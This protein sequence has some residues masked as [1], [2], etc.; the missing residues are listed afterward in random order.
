MSVQTLILWFKGNKMTMTTPFSSRPLIR[1][2][3][4]GKMAP[5][6]RWIWSIIL[7]RLLA[8]GMGVDGSLW[9]HKTRE[10]SLLL[11]TCIRFRDRALKIWSCMQ[12]FDLASLP[13]RQH[14]CCKQCRCIVTRGVEKAC[15]HWESMSLLSAI[16]AA[17]NWV[18]FQIQLLNFFLGGQS[19]SVRDD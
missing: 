6:Q 2:V 14:V 18:L 11:V 5:Q 8:Q 12:G 4:P 9:S 17:T 19:N 1:A 7:C 15:L 13:G 16:T 10:S 3:C